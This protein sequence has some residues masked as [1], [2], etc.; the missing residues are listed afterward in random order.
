MKYSSDVEAAEAMKIAYEKIRSEIGKVIVGQD[1]VV[2]KLLT[3]IFC[4]GHCLL[5]GVPG[6][7]KTLLIQTIASSLDLK[8][9][10]IQFTP[11]L[12]PSDILGSETLDQNRNFKFIRGPIF[13]NIILAD[14][15]NRTPPKTQS[16][17]LE[18]M[19]EYSVTI[20]GAKHSLD[21]P[22]FVLATQNPIEQEGTYPLPEAQL[23]R[24]MFMIQLDYPSYAE[25]VSI[26]KSTTSDNKYQVKEVITAE[27]IMD[28]QH[29]V[30]RVPVT[31]HVIEYAVKLVHK[32]RPTSTHAV[33]DTNDYLE[34]GAGPRASQALILA[35]KCNAL[36]SG[37]YS[38][39]I[40]DIKAVA[41]PVLRHRIIRNFKAEA[42]GISVDDIIARLV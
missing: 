22:F 21:R 17:L 11:D 42:E 39:D 28:F 38:P 10:R 9:N 15:I 13:A 14:E 35:A 31:D 8:F 25:E 41:L 19:Q 20:A 27:E 29:L 5:V 1:D 34:W 30:R 24:F 36:L 2:K 7:A 37:K 4:Q 26:V 6:L 33:K 23:D 40:E 32:T 16:A 3:A 12:M 18:A